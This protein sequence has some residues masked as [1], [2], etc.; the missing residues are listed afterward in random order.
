[1]QYLTH[2]VIYRE[3]GY[4]VSIILSTKDYFIY[5]LWMIFSHSEHILF[6]LNLI[7]KVNL[8]HKLKQSHLSDDLTL[9]LFI[10]EN[11]DFTQA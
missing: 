11:E 7:M 6:N 5:E 3:F 9:S 10:Y 1:M 4:H 2:K 8:P